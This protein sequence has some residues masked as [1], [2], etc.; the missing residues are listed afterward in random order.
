MNAFEEF[1]TVSNS[2]VVYKGV[3]VAST[4]VVNA[5]RAKTDLLDGYYVIEGK[6]DMAVAIPKLGIPSMEISLYLRDVL[7]RHS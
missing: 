2:A 5:M 4:Q 7:Q 3:G 6:G 1:R